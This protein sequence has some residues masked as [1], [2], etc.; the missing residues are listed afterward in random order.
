MTAP[1]PKKVTDYLAAVKY[2]TDAEYV[3]SSFALEMLNLIKLI[4][5]GMTENTTPSIHLKILDSFIDESGKDIIN[6]CHRGAA[7]TTLLEYIIFRIALY[8][9]LPNLGKIPHMIFRGYR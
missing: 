4:D 3:P 5:G 9:E 6:L 2:G 7:K 8:G 1:F